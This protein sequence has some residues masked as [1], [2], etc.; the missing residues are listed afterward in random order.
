VSHFKNKREIRYSLKTDSKKLAIKR[1]RAYRVQFES[2]ID[3]LMANNHETARVKLIVNDILA[4]KSKTQQGVENKF[5]SDMLAGIDSETQNTID[6]NLAEMRLITY[7]DQNG[8]TTSIDYNGDVEKE[9]QAYLVMQGVTPAKAAPNP[10]GKKFS[11]HLKSFIAYQTRPELKDGWNSPDTQKIKTGILKH[12]CNDIGDLTTDQFD[13]ERAKE[14]VRW[15]HFMPTLFRNTRG[16][17]FL[18]VTVDAILTGAFDASE[19]PKRKP[20]TIQ[21]DLKTVASF[22]EWIR[23]H[24]RVASL[25]ESVDVLSTAVGEINP[26]IIQ[27]NLSW[28]VILAVTK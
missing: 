10:I 14:Y 27:C 22:L 2:I 15:A 17:R 23:K 4:D 1:A 8:N 24:E 9:T 18:D 21:V 13:W 7:V 19:Y 5:V 16:K 11:E 25:Q 12:F 20:S 28:P 26:V 6:S 3:G